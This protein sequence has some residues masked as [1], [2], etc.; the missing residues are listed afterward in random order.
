MEKQIGCLIK[1][2]RS[3]D[4]LEYTLKEFHKFCKEERIERQH[5]IRY[6]PQQNGVFEP[7]NQINVEMVKSMMHANR[8]PI[9]IWTQAVYTAVYLTNRCLTKAV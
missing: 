3:D 8:L 9:T 5:T 2:L 4:G 6:T 7:K 1:T